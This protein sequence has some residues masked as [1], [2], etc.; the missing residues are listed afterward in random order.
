MVLNHYDAYSKFVSSRGPRRTELVKGYSIKRH[1]ARVKAILF[2]ALSFASFAFANEAADDEAD[3]AAIHHTIADLNWLA[4]RSSPFTADANVAEEL[5]HLPRVP[6]WRS[7]AYSVLW[8]GPPTVTI[9]KEPWGEATITF[10]GFSSF[11]EVS[12]HPI[13]IP[14]ITSG[15]IRYITPDVALVEGTWTSEGDGVATRTVPLLFVM[16]R[17][18][19]KWKIASIRTLASP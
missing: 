16:K 4:M 2:V 11:P 14:K 6:Y 15:A 12:A 10:P 17:E 5:G 7:S 8:A 13:P 3:T 9:S 1:T 18:A 19:D